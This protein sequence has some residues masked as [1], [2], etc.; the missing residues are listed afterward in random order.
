MVNWRSWRSVFLP[1][2]AVGALS[3]GVTE[4]RVGV[5]YTPPIMTFIGTVIVIVSTIAI[6]YEKRKQKESDSR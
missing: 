6:E 4:P 1:M 5:I 2:M 3:M